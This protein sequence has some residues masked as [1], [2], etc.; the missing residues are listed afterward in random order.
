MVV[1]RL[2]MRSGVNSTSNVIP[3][4]P[5][6]APGQAPESRC[7]YISRVKVNSNRTS[8]TIQLLKGKVANIFLDVKDFFKLCKRRYYWK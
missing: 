8:G 2:I 5:Q 3:A 6:S 4:D 7:L 1:L